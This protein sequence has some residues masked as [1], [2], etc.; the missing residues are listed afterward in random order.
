MQQTSPDAKRYGRGTIG[1]VAAAFI[2][3][4]M[5]PS[6][7]QAQSTGNSPGNHPRVQ[8]ARHLRRAACSFKS[9]GTTCSFSLGGQTFTG[10]CEDVGQGQMACRNAVSKGGLERSDVAPDGGMSAG[11][12]PQ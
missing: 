12:I 2:A 3:A 8:E 6:I 1:K 5:L 9:V 7:A 11:D 10:V 4:L